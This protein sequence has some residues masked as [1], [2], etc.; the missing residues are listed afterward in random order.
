M[1]RAAFVD[2]SILVRFLVQDIP[3]QS[4]RAVHLFSQ[5][6]AHEIRV[7]MSETVILETTYVL[8][9]VYGVPR[10]VAG[11]LLEDI[12]DLEEL[13]L[14]NKSIVQEALRHWTEQGPLSF[15]DCYHLALTAAFDLDEIYSFDK[16]MGRY[17]GATRIEP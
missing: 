1:T 4:S 17:P 10:V 6:A 8:T 9:K 7:F 11:S 14:H 12:L 15:A 2:T 13:I 3:D 5:V 16:K